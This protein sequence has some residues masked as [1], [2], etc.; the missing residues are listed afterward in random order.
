MVEIIRGFMKDEGG[1]TA[2][3]YGLLA[4][5]ISLAAGGMVMQLGDVVQE[6][7][8]YVLDWVQQSEDG[9]V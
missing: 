9:T 4:A 8:Q 7:Y 3:E 2:V 5:L 1:A 6:V